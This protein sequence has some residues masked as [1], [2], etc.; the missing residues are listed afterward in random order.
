MALHSSTTTTTFRTFSNKIIYLISMPA[1]IAPSCVASVPQGTLRLGDFPRVALPSA[2]LPNL[3]PAPLNPLARKTQRQK[4]SFGTFAD[5]LMC[6]GSRAQI[7]IPLSE[8]LKS[9]LSESFLFVLVCV[10]A[11]AGRPVAATSEAKVEDNFIPVMRPEDL[12]KGNQMAVSFSPNLLQLQSLLGDK[13]GS[14]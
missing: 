1:V 3:K 5:L 7:L 13:F 2:K 10:S 8:R 12:P 11:S 9:F 14:N 6:T 4:L